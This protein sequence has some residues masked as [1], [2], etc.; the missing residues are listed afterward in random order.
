MRDVFV[1]CPTCGE[2]VF[3]TVVDE[4]IEGILLRSSADIVAAQDK[5]ALGCKAMESGRHDG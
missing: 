4:R 3:Y 2:H 5:V 1:T